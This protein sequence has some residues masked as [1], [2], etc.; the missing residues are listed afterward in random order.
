MATV[1]GVVRSANLGYLASYPTTSISQVGVRRKGWGI[2]ELK[3]LA[4]VVDPCRV[5]LA[6]VNMLKPHMYNQ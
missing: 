3:M 5:W 1:V 4:L 6:Y 2:D